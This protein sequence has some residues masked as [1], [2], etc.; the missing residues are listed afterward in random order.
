M[1]KQ[2]ILLLLKFE[3]TYLVQAMQEYIQ[4]YILEYIHTH[5]HR[6][7][8]TDRQTDRQ[9][10]RQAC[11]HVCMHACMHACKQTYLIAKVTPS[12]ASS[13]YLCAYKPEHLLTTLPTYK[14]AAKYSKNCF[15][16]SENKFLGV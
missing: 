13:L 10:G 11:M 15:T 14:D 2:V 12:L 1:Q 7:R 6:Y 5:I 3:S 8:H 4:E 16:D 9:T